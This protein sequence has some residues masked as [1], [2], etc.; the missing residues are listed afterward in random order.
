MTNR[1]RAIFD[2]V[3]DIN[4]FVH[5]GSVHHHHH[6]DVLADDDLTLTEKR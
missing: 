3:Y 1:V 5:L 4:A 6:R 2:N